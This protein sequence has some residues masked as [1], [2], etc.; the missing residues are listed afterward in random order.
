MS[1]QFVDS[2]C[3]G[4]VS[5]AELDR[6]KSMIQNDYLGFRFDPEY[7]HL[8][9]RCNG[10]EPVT[11]YFRAP[12]GLLAPPV[13]RFLHYAQLSSLTDR[14]LAFF[15]ANVFWS[16]LDDRL[17]KLLPFAVLGNNDA[18]CFDC[19]SK[20]SAVFLWSN[21]NSV[22]DAPSYERISDSFGEFCELLSSTPS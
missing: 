8:L 6:M 15:H 18:L 21:E 20:S 5:P 4:P 2:S 11:K 10:G 1:L 14:S 12:S 19:S 22:E 9:Q 16:A 17:G 13:E 3:V 7:V